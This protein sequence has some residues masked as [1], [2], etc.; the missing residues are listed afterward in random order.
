M[1]YYTQEAIRKLS[2]IVRI[3][4]DFFKKSITGS[5]AKKAQPTSQTVLVTPQTLGVSSQVLTMPKL[6]SITTTIPTITNV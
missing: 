5:T 6:V 2:R 4:S 1:L 3:P